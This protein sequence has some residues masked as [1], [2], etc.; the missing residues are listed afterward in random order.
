MKFLAQLAIHMLIRQFFSALLSSQASNGSLQF[1]ALLHNCIL[2]I[3]KTRAYTV[4]RVGFYLCLQMRLGYK[5]LTESNTLAYYNSEFK[6]L[7]GEL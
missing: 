1:L 5:P 4:L 2:V 3:L 6:K 7:Y